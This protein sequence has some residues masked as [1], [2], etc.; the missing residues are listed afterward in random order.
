MH[1]SL[2]MMRK[3]ASVHTRHAVR[4]RSLVGAL[5]GCKKLVDDL[6]GDQRPNRRFNVVSYE[7]F[8]R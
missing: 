1:Y 3:Y 8:P 5:K 7:R 2:S 4:W 6:L